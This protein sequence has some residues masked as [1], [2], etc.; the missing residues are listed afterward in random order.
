[1]YGTTNTPRDHG[2]AAT[3]NKS[4]RSTVSTAL[5]RRW[6]FLVNTTTRTVLRTVGDP[7]ELDFDAAMR[8][9]MPATH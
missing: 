2:G 7:D 8:R 6:T 4:I 3:T 5:K 9:A 1:M